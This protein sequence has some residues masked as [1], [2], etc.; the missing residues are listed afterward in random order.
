MIVLFSCDPGHIRD[1]AS[2]SFAKRER[3]A[4]EQYF[5]KEQQKA[6]D[7]LKGHLHDEIE[8]H[9]EEI[10][11]LQESIKRHEEKVKKLEEDKPKE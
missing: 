2:G 8:N 5:R 4:E 3:A 9:K 6:I 1:D 11:R 10:R 7:S